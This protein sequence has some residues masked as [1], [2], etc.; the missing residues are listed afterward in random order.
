[1]I[2]FYGS[3]RADDLEMSTDLRRLPETDRRSGRS[4]P[5][6]ARSPSK[7]PPC[8]TLDLKGWVYVEIKSTEISTSIHLEPRSGFRGTFS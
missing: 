1:M 5:R 8:Q 6:H 4:D 2:L 3:G 7:D